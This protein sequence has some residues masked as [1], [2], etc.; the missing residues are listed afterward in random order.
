MTYFVDGDFQN[1]SLKEVF[2]NHRQAFG[3]YQGEYPLLVKIISANDYLSVQ[4]HPDDLYAQ[5]HN[6]S[7]GKPES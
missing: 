5:E 2:E 1:Q 6:Q 4:V 3:N 7:L